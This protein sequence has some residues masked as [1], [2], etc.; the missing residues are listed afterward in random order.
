MLLALPP[1][2][3]PLERA[4]AS[5]THDA[6]RVSHFRVAETKEGR[7]QGG[8]HRSPSSRG[9]NPSSWE[10]EGENIEES[11]WRT[12]ASNVKSRHPRSVIKS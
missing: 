2:S 4:C 9:E 11:G 7:V 8:E 3:R 12:R 6:Y 5:P 1:N 10:T